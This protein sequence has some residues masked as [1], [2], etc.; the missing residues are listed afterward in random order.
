VRWR[1][2]ERGNVSLREGMERREREKEGDEK[3]EGEGR[4]E[5]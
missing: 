1:E 2:G 4:K 5:E 3:E